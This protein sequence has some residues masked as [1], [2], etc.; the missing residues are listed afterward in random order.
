VHCVGVSTL[1]AVRPAPPAPPAPPAGSGSGSRNAGRAAR[2]I[3]RSSPRSFASSGPLPTSTACNR[4]SPTPPAARGAPPAAGQARAPRCGLTSFVRTNLS[5][6]P[7]VVVGGVIPEQDYEQLYKARP[8]RACDAP[9]PRVRGS[10][11][12]RSH[13]APPRPRRLERLRRLVLF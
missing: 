12:P 4:C 6:V 5:Q 2:G 8:A 13:G 9:R 10:D 7:E 3:A 11:T 1:A